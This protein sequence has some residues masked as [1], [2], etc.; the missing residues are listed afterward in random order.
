MAEIDLST[1]KG[2]GIIRRKPLKEEVP[3]TGLEPARG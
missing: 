3:E 1:E 2:Y